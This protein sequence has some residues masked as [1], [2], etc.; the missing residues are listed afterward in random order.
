[1]PMIKNPTLYN[2][3][4]GAATR[5]LAG[6]STLPTL[7]LP[8]GKAV[9]RY[10]QYRDSMPQPEKAGRTIWT[11]LAGD[12]LNRWT[13]LGAGD[14][15][16]GAQGLYCSGE[17]LDKDKPFPELEHYMDPNTSADP[18]YYFE[19]TPNQP[20]QLRLAN[21]KSLRS[22]FL[23]STK[24]EVPGLD[25][26]LPEEGNPL[27]Q[28]IFRDAR[29]K[30]P[31]AFGPGDTLATLYHASEDASLCRAIGNAVFES[32]DY[33]FVQVTSV[34]DRVSPNIVFKGTTGQ[35][36]DV[37]KPEGR[38]TFFLNPQGGGAKG[39]FT[40][41]DLQYNATFE[42]TGLGVLP[43]R[44]QMKGQ[45]SDIA[46]QVVDTL[47]DQYVRELQNYAPTSK[48]EAVGESLQR[49]RDVLGGDKPET[50]VDQIGALQKSL[51]DLPHQNLQQYEMDA[52]TTVQK[53]T[54]SLS[55]ITEA[56][57]TA[58]EEIDSGQRDDSDEVEP[59]E[60]PPEEEVFP[61]EKVESGGG[62]L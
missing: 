21:V 46:L 7:R 17:F 23:F 54:K 60:D 10:T 25:L 39:V 45:L 57:K 20:P 22:M 53:V 29:S 47:T 38:S 34:R 51:E 31:E 59:M 58:G 13:G 27:L 14:L 28:D 5:R 33:Q 40:I 32:T 52:M 43:S 12:K 61:K 18:V 9:Y 36:L 11:Q 35:P 4:F 44:E 55:S 15:S 62:A 1:M 48:T 26:S 30:F 50:A 56:I 24:E 49:I 3:V 37:L 8:Q 19:Y 41:L 42:E 16:K 6:G 2:A